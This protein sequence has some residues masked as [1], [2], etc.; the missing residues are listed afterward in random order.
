MATAPLVL[1]H[2]LRVALLGGEL[3][4]TW[5]VRARYYFAPYRRFGLRLSFAT[6]SHGTRP[7][8]LV[9]ELRGLVSMREHRRRAMAEMRLPP[10]LGL[11]PAGR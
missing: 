4:S 2:P 10:E 5:H 7:R 3:T 11:P 8:V 1:D 9:E 6:T